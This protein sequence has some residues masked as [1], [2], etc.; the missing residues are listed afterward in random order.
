VRATDLVEDA[1]LMVE[2]LSEEAVHSAHIEA[3]EGLQALFYNGA[4]KYPAL[5][6][7]VE[8][9]TGPSASRIKQTRERQF[10]SFKSELIE[11]HE[12]AL[13]ILSTAGLVPSYE[14]YPAAEDDAVGS[15]ITDLFTLYTPQSDPE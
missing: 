13:E 15:M 8:T 10:E 2:Q 9:A 7:A 4:W 3:L 6:I 5:R 1:L 14:D 11:R 12:E